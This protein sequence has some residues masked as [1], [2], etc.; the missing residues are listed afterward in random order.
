MPHFI[1]AR[2]PFQKRAKL[3]AARGMPQFP[4]RLR[5]DLTNALARDG[6]AL[7]DF[8][9]RVLAAVADAK[10]HLDDLLLARRER[11]QPPL[12]LFLQVQI[13]DRFGRRHDLTIFDEVAEMRIFLFADGRFE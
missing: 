6:E 3:A 2:A 10:S 7:P 9:E 11:I 12:G 5:F 1:L 4:E 8:F 13:D